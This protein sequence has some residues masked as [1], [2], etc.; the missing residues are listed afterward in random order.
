MPGNSSHSISPADFW[1]PWTEPH[2]TSSHLLGSS[3]PGNLCSSRKGHRLQL[4][5]R[6]R[7]RYTSRSAFRNR[8]TLAFV[9][10]LSTCHV[11][12]QQGASAS[13]LPDTPSS[14]QPMKPQSNAVNLLAGRSRVL[15][16]LAV[17]SQPMTDKEKLQLAIYNALSPVTV[18]GAAAGAGISQAR[19]TRKGYGQ[20]AEGYFKRWGAAMAFASS[21][22][23]IGAYAVASML[24]EDPRYFVGNSGKFRESVRY[25][26]S[27]VFICRKDDGSTTT[28]WAGILGP[29][30]AAGLA[31]AYLPADSQ[32][33][34]HTFGNWGVSLAFAAGT[35]VFRE[36]WPH[37]NKKLRLPPMDIDSGPGTMEPKKTATPTIPQ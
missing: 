20:G 3:G 35:K 26:V 31:N 11:V 19:N 36:Y 23:L 21:N 30:G 24:H 7:T 13:Q 29:L 22:Q 16:N 17:N 10:A 1:G 4:K 8:L 27:R 12:G 32:G 25:A 18:I 2:V 28:N 14:T 34:G 37:I 33:V 9:L 5:P 15:P 6:A